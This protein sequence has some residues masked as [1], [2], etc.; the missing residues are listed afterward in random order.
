MKSRVTKNG[1]NGFI[2]R[3]N[4]AEERNSELEDESV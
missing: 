1:F 2:S 4:T 3:L